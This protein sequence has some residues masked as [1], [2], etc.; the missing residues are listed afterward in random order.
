[1]SVIGRNPFPADTFIN[2]KVVCVVRNSRGGGEG[3]I[4]HTPPQDNENK[5]GADSRL[6]ETDVQAGLLHFTEHVLI[7]S[8]ADESATYS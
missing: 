7:C 3:S 5:R 4:H 1:M 2:I 6:S 8:S